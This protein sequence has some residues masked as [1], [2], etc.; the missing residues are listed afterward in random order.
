MSEGAVH[1]NHLGKNLQ[2]VI[3]LKSLGEGTVQ[4]QGVKLGMIGIEDAEEN[5]IALPPDTKGGN[6]DPLPEVL[7]GPQG[8]RLQLQ[9]IALDQRRLTVTKEVQKVRTKDL[10]KC[11]H[12]VAGEVYR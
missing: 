7:A 3:V 2:E 5:R 6:A 10:K 11:V 8:K 1:Q 12:P 4:I 9:S